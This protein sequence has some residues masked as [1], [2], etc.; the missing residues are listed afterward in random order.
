M[1]W[2]VGGKEI[3]ESIATLC[4]EQEV[5]VLLLAE[6]KTQQSDMSMS[7]N[8]PKRAPGTYRELPHLDSRI[9][10]FTRFSSNRF[11]PVFDDGHVRILHLRL[12]IGRPLLIVAAHLPSKLW[13]NAGD[14]SY[15]IRQLRQDIEA[16][17]AKTGHKNTVVIGDLNAN[18]FEDSLMA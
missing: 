14:Q 5:D 9:R 8:T 12:P 15:R 4:R 2:N 10:V 13:S 11:D 3:P 16:A 17:E 18:P 6:C 7:L 1:F